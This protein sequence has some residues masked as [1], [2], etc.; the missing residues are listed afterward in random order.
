MVNELNLKISPNQYM[1]K[2]LKE[3]SDNFPQHK[4]V[5]KILCEFFRNRSCHTLITPE[6]DPSV[7]QNP[8]FVEQLIKLKKIL[9]GVPSLDLNGG[10][11]S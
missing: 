4:E 3:Y 6:T 10:T 1:E 7:E 2:S 5:Y 9:T 8:E 11:L